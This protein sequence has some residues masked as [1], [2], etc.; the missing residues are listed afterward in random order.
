MS[1][2]ISTAFLMGGLGNQMFQAAHAL[3]QGKKNNVPVRFKC[4]SWTPMQG[5]QTPAYKENIFRNLD[6]NWVDL[7]LNRVVEGPWE[8]SE[9]VADWT[10]PTEFYGYFQ[11]SKNFL[12]YDQHIRE[13]FS[14]TQKFKE[15]IY[16]KYPQMNQDN[17]VSIHIR[18]GD[19]KNNPH[20]HPS[21]SIEY[22][23]RALREIGEYSHAFIFSEDKE[24]ITNNLN[25]E[26]STVVNEEDWTEMWMISLCKNNINSNSTFS[27]WGAFLNENPNKKVIAPSIWFG[28]SGPQ[29][30]K[31]IFEPYWTVLDVQY[32]NGL[33]K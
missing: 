4:E 14:P 6:F 10:R 19:Y 2:V 1:E 31:D 13:V 15:E 5:R 16:E 20:I 11:S 23:N 7:P 32:D 8:Y 9:I 17:T 33:L 3:A 24:W 25:L 28:P 12:G 27:W 26:N 21:I 18:L 29:N 30:Y 22:I